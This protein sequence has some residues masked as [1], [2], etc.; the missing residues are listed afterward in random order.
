M[1]G[2]HKKDD[3]NEQAERIADEAAQ[4]LREMG[5]GAREHAEDVKTEAVRLLNDAADAIRK[6]ARKAGARGELRGGA[7]DV[8]HG[9]ERAAHYLKH[10]SFE[11]MGA[12]VTRSAKANPWRVAA[13]VFFVGLVIGLLMRGDDG[14]HGAHPGPGDHRSHNGR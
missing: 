10:N 9:L 1:F 2:N 8:A 3:V 7:D 6:E 11:D 12:D 14:D 4:N 5:R 13:I